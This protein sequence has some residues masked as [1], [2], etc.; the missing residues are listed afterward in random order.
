MK[1]D[2]RNVIYETFEDGH[3]IKKIKYLDKNYKLSRTDGPA[4][5]EFMISTRLYDKCLQLIVVLF[6]RMNLKKS[7]ATMDGLSI[8]LSQTSSKST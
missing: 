5:V 3:T 7:M 4:L 8:T 6:P 1:S 2:N